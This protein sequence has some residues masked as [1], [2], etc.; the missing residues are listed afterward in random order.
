MELADRLDDLD[1]LIKE[2]AP[3]VYEFW[4]ERRDSSEDQG[5]RTGRL[6]ENHILGIILKH[7][8]E[9]DPEVTT[10]DIEEQYKIFFK[11]I[12]RSTVS[13]YLNQL[14]KEGV[15]YKKRDGRTVKYLFNIPPPPDIPGFWIV[16]NF[17]LLPPYLS[18]ASLL[19]QLYF[20]P[21]KK[22]EKYEE[23]RKFFLGLTILTILK[24]RLDKCRLCQFGNRSFYQESTELMSSYIKER[25]DV[26]PEEL[27]NF[28]L[29]ELGELPL[30]NGIKV[31]PD[32]LNEINEKIID[33]VERF[34]SDIEF[35]ISVSKHRQKVHLNQ[36]D[37]KTK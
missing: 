18:R 30:F 11:K 5:I 8:L 32:K 29:F 9:G 4:E 10:T 34:H 22:V 7:Y 33:Y 3:E 14:E 19:S 37:S 20:N 21:P 6:H 16:R 28:I 31:E 2:Y 13:T 26:L 12:A 17:C 15:L 36:M 1:K 35:Q 23:E 25:I 27:R 24:N